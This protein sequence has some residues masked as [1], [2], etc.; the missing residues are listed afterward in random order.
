MPSD[1]F[2]VRKIYPD[3]VRNPMFWRIT[4]NDKD[5][6]MNI[7]G[8]LKKFTKNND[9]YSFEEGNDVG[10]INVYTNAKYYPT[11]IE[12]NHSLCAA[13]GYM[14]SKVDWKNVEATA[15]INLI[16]NSSNPE[17]AFYISARGGKHNRNGPDC[18]G[19]AY[20]GIVYYDG[21]ITFAKEQYHENL[22]YL[23]ASEIQSLGS[24]NNMWLGVKFIIYN[25]VT[26]DPDK[27]DNPDVVLELWLDIDNSNNWKKVFSYKDSKG[28]GKMG[29]TC[30]GLT[31]DQKGTWG[32]PVVSFGWDNCES[33][34]FKSM[35]VREIDPFIV[36]NEGGANILEQMNRAGSTGRTGTG[37]RRPL[38]KT[39][40]EEK[41]NIQNG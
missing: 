26:D 18:E 1:I 9:V 13:K 10:R 12:K 17:N 11:L 21:E 7:E 5:P 28:W 33:I 37:S 14:M 22:Y 41:V 3:S 4:S 34:Q 32:G 35:S 40:V 8:N 36:F 30:N 15:Y 39:F 2:R 25:D 27:N 38:L 29:L 19:F 31:D 24:M 6:R 23:D 16:S 20:M